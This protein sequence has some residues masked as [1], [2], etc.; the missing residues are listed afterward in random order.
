LNIYIIAKGNRKNILTISEIYSLTVEVVPN[1]P[2]YI[3][4][5]HGKEQT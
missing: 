2:S 5:L 4:K 3:S 1:C